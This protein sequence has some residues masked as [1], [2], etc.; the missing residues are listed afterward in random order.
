MERKSCPYMNMLA[1]CIEDKCEFWFKGETEEEGTGCL[2]KIACLAS[3][4][5]HSTLMEFQAVMGEEF[6]DILERLANQIHE[7][8]KDAPVEEP[9]KIEAKK[10]KKTEKV[11]AS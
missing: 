9:P 2:K 11:K 8:E 5:T 10:T 4:G 1:P 7:E 3:I 6:A